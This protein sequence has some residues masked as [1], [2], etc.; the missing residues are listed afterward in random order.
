LNNSS[1]DHSDGEVDFAP[2]EHTRSSGFKYR[3]GFGERPRFS[4][5]VD[6]SLLA[7]I[8]YNDL[9]QTHMSLTTLFYLRSLFTFK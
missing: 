1:R 9:F 6:L 8:Q 3:S 5:W 4:V 2:L 7:I